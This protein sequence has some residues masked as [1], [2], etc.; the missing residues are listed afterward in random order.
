MT[1]E[2]NT[3]IWSTRLQRELL[4]LT[5]D[6]APEDTKE[7]V[8]C[9]LPPFVSVKDHQLD[10][11]KGDCMVSFLIDLP[12]RKEDKA[13]GE[14]LEEAEAATTPSTGTDEE[15]QVEGKDDSGAEP[16]EGQDA[17][18]KKSDD[19]EQKK[20]DDDIPRK[21][22]VTLDAS[23]QKKND[24]SVDPIAVAYPFLKPRAILASGSNFF[25]E[26]STIK[27]GD[28]IDIEMDWTPS[29]HL[30][31]AILNI[32]LKIKESILQ[33]EAFHPAAKEKNDPVEEIVNKARRFG[34]SFTNSL[35]GITQKA[36]EKPDQKQQKKGLRG[37]GRKKKEE[38]KKPKSNSGEVRIGDE[39]NMLESPWV[40]CQGVYSCK[41]I[42][43]PAFVDD[44]ISVAA[45]ATE[46]EQVR[47][48]LDQDD[49]EP[50][51]SLSDYMRLQAGSIGQVCGAIRKRLLSWKRLC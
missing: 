30:T 32:G 1:A 13:T 41:A 40:D 28:F 15:Q 44:A 35:R 26:G 37:L 14:A 47:S 43:R 29:L 20:G 18:Q 39:I 22:I 42:R 31:D 49:G 34:S 51:D 19:A 3:E 46:G 48:M 24:G 38:N 17:E 27:E 23:L 10:I 45:Q 50:P 8:K 16:K 21:M 5:T 33:D 25:P 6:N 7:E 36:T 11:A 12:P 2:R 4:A 9:V